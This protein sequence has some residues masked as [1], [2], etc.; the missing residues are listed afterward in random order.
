M[1]GVPPKAL[2]MQAKGMNN[3]EGE[4]ATAFL[5]LEDC[6]GLCTNRAVI[7]HYM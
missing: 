2:K 1:T 6:T 3:S 4:T 7:L 5:M